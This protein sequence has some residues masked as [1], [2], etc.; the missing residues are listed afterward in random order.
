MSYPIVTLL[1][2]FGL[3][4][5]YVGIMKGQ[6]LKLCPTAALVDLTHEIAR[7]D[8]RSASFHL[9]QAV[10]YFPDGTLHLA[11][12]DPGVGTSR[13]ILAVRTETALF[14]APDNG[15]LSRALNLL[16]PPLES[17]ELP[18]PPRSSA[19]FHGRDVMAPAAARLASGT[20]LKEL[21]VPC[22]EILQLDFPPPELGS[23]RVGASVLVVDHFGNVTLDL[24]QQL[25]E[26]LFEQGSR[27]SLEGQELTM[28]KTY[29]DLCPGQ[30]M[31]LWSSHG[32]L[33][34]ACREARAD[35]RWKGLVPGARVELQ[36][37]AGS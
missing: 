37:L 28:A 8:V 14:V 6:I 25:G 31:L 10:D 23:D 7:Q 34:L 19:T 29:G 20:A 22:S 17:V 21:G 12:V 5:P 13:R 9:E 4:D 27:W 24:S 33:E 1:T 18:V 26:G 3:R 30:A 2:D 11:V 32:L 15:L 35:Q 16:G 36:R